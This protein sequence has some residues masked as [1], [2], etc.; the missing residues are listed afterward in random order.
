MCAQPQ[1][2]KIK[3]QTCSPANSDCLQLFYF[4]CKCFN[5]RLWTDLD[6]LSVRVNDATDAP[7]TKSKDVKRLSV[8]NSS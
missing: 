3:A 7:V 1:I 8:H 5:I 2:F 4:S 6:Q